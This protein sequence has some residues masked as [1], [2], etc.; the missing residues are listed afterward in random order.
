MDERKPVEE[1]LAQPAAPPPPKRHVRSRLDNVDAAM[2]VGLAGENVDKLLG[3]LTE[4]ERE[5]FY[6]LLGQLRETGDIDLDGIWKIDYIKRPPTMEEFIT[7]PYWV[8]SITVKSDESAGLFSEWKRVLCRDFNLDSRIHNCVITGSLGIGKS[9]VA[10]L[11]MCYRIVLVK[12]LRNPHNFL[13]LGKGSKILYVLLSVTKTAVSQTIYGDVINFMS[14]SPF[15]LEECHF[16]PKLKYSSFEI[17]LG[18]S[19]YLTAGSQA[20][21]I[22]GRNTPGI[23]MDEGNF[24]LEKNPDLSAYTL[25]NEVRTRLKNR[26]QKLSGFL[27]GISILASSSADENS[28]TEQVIADINAVND[29]NTQRVYRYA[30]YRIKREQLT[31]SNKWFRVAYGLKNMDPKVLFGYVTEQGEPIEGDKEVLEPV[32]DGARVELVPEDYQQEFARNCTLSLQ[33]LSGISTGATYRLFATTTDLDRAVTDG[34]EAGLV[35]P[36]TEDIFSLSDEDDMQIYDHLEHSRF[37]T[38][39]GGRIVPKRDPDALRFAHFDL[40][41]THQAGVAICHIV[42]NQLV[43]KVYNRLTN[44]VYDEYRVLVEYDFILAITAGK[45]KPISIRKIQNLFFWLRERCGYQFGLI[46][47]DTYQSELPQQDLI[48][49]GFKAEV[50]S[51]DK[52]KDPY[53]AWREAFQERRIRWFRHHTVMR[54]AA[55]LVDGPKKVDHPPTTAD[56]EAVGG[57][58]CL[59]ADTRI[60]LLD[61]TNPTIQE[62]AESATKEF[63]VYSWDG[64]KMTVGRAYNPR[65]TGRSR[66]TVIVG[67]DNGEAVTCTP[68]HRFMLRDGTYRAAGELRA[69]DSLMPLYRKISKRSSRAGKLTGLAGYEM[70]WCPG[71]GQWHFTHRMVG[72]WKYGLPCR[73]GFVYHHEKGKLNN[74]PRHLVK[75]SKKEHGLVHAADLLARRA[76]PAFEANRKEKLYA[77]IRSDEGRKN[78]SERMSALN[79]T[80]DFKTDQIARLAEVGRQWGKTNITLYNKSEAHRRTASRVGKI[81]IRAAH[82]ARSKKYAHATADAIVTAVRCGTV[83][84]IHQAASTFKCSMSLIWRRL[85]GHSDYGFVHG[86]FY[87]AGVDALRLSK[88]KY[89]GDKIADLLRQK[90]SPKDIAA[91]VGCTR[92]LVYWHRHKLKNHKVVSVADGPACDVYDISVEGFCN[93]S[94]SVGIQLHNSKDCTDSCAGAYYDAFMHGRTSSLVNRTGDGGFTGSMDKPAEEEGTPNFGFVPTPPPRNVQTFTV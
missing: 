28:M 14:N 17:P 32:P 47:S 21:H 53:Y 85:K 48:N 77:V 4:T 82:A 73:R 79:S 59:A 57:E 41:K 10:A 34:E 30:V 12:M 27:P 54:E 74:D 45:T 60:A 75:M 44:G 93:F 39:K 31:L 18:D 38:R 63:Y 46:T 36:C 19:I 52:T 76:D 11:I 58:G 1:V 3:Y 6:E 8:G 2:E 88:T 50:L 40:A 16:N 25:F 89:D 15:F 71:D 62:L 81:T 92:E 67:L 83:T 35:N 7:D 56:M 94:L 69:G 24:R 23:A 90:L 22:L 20:Q 42:G 84:S 64:S 29:L 66:K 80:A 51:V 49:G 9:Y 72:G 65:L 61:G 70:Y 78:A 33:R 86:V 26:F 5:L 87:R 37:L 68:D 43:E 55:E 13:N 91:A